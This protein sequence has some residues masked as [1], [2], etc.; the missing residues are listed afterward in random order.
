MLQIHFLGC[1][2]LHT[3]VLAVTDHKEG[4]IVNIV[5]ITDLEGISGVDTMEMVSEKCTPGHRFAL[6]RLMLDANAAI[7]GLFEGGANKVYVIDGHGSGNNFIQ[8]ILD[9][10][11]IH[12]ISGGAWGAWYD[13]IKKGEIDACIEIGLHAMPGTI[14]GFLDHTQSS[15]SWYNYIVNGRKS[16]EIAQGAI[17]AGAYDVPFIMVSGDE[18]ACV[19]AREFL[20]DIECAVVKYGIG[21]NK[22]RLVDL[23]E[24]LNRIKEAACKSIRLIGS[25][26]PYKPLMPL[27][28]KIEYYRTDMCKSRLERDANVERIDARAVRKIVYKIESYHD[29]L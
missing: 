16:G 1:C 24:A 15:K 2:G 26:K 9:P 12:L 25:A 11:A 27:E 23:D 29:I 14:N 3:I 20:G 28:I 10:R 21:R 6:E 7:E 5:I 19:E 17:F 13:L 8:E 22:A 18:A 4:I